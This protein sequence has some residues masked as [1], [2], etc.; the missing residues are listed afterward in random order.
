MKPIL[1]ASALVVA[2]V[3]GAMA[4]P[5]FPTLPLLSFPGDTSG[6]V[7]TQGGP[8]LPLIPQAAD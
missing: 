2:G 1:F 6:S 4:G 5:T 7:S 8:V 3:A